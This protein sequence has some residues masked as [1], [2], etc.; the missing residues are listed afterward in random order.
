MNLQSRKHSSMA[1]RDEPLVRTRRFDSLLMLA[2]EAAAL[3]GDYYS[4]DPQDCE[5]EF[6][7]AD[8]RR[9][10]RWFGRRHQ[11]FDFA[12]ACRRIAR[13]TGFFEWQIP[14]FILCGTK[15]TLP[16]VAIKHESDDLIGPPDGSARMTLRDYERPASGAVLVRFQVPDISIK[17]LREVHRLVKKSWKRGSEKPH[18]ASRHS[19]KSAS[20]SRLTPSDELLYEI[21]SDLDG[22]GDGRS[23]HGLWNDVKEEWD[24]RSDKPTTKHALTMKGKRLKK[25]LREAGIRHVTPEP[26]EE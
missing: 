12:Q 11:V 17:D 7:S 6:I 5:L 21:L 10:R 9:V 16:R 22:L 3:T 24:R 18:G 13:S 23:R 20:R 19:K 26:G 25:K 2:D 15:P 14:P 8:K 1:R 4:F